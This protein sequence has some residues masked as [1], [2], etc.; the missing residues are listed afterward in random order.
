MSGKLSA[1]LLLYRRGRQD[2]QTRLEV[3]LVHMGGPYWARKDEG[4][5]SIPKGEYEPGEDPLDAAKR[6]FEEELGSAPPSVVYRELGSVRQAGGKLVT[7]Y[8]AEADFD[9]DGAVS[10]H[11]ELEWPRGSGKMQSFP[12][13]DRAS[14]FTVEAARVSLVKGQRPLVDRL[15]PG[16]QSQT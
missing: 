8:A 10:N 13:I 1:G 15:L 6:E 16:F 11:F 14:W 7:A 3:L 5:W 2:S 4:A 12:E 9:A